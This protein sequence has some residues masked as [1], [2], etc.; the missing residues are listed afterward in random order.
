MQKNAIAVDLKQST[1]QTSSTKHTLLIVDDE[2]RVLKALKRVFTDDNYKILTAENGQAALDILTINN[3]DLIISDYSMPGM[4]GIELLKIIREKYPNTI[5]IM[6]TAH[7]DSDLVM[8]AVN[9]GAVYK[10]I[11][12][13][14][15]DDD[16][17]LTIKLALAQ[18]D[19]IKENKKLKKVAQRQSNEINKLKYFASIDH[20][21]LGTI[22]IDKGI[23]LPGQLEM[24][25]KYRKQNNTILV[26]S[27]IDLGM[28]EEEVLLKVIQELSKSDFA[29]FEEFRLESDFSRL[30]PREACEIGCLAPVRKEDKHIYVAMADPLD[31]ERIE[32]IKFV[33]QMNVTALLARLAEIEKAIK[34]IYDGPENKIDIITEA[35]DEIDIVLDEEDVTTT[36]QLMAK[37]STPP[38]IRMVNTIIGEAIRAEASDIHIE[39]K[40]QYTLVRFRIDGLLHD[41]I[42]LPSTMHLSTISRLKILAKMDIAERRIPQDGRITIKFNDKL[43]DTRVSSMPT[44]NGEKMV[45]RLLEKNAAIKSLTETGIRGKSYDRLI[46]ITSVPQGMIIATGPTGSGKTTTLYSMMKKR[47]SN[48]QNFVTIEDPVEYLLEKASQIHIHNKI[49]LTFASSLRSTLRQDP[50]VILVGE[51][52]DL[53]TAKAAFQAAMTGHLVF[54]S[55]HTNSTIATISRLFHLGIEPF[56]V[57]SA[58]QG[59][60]AQRLVRK[61]CPHCKELKNYDKNLLDILSAENIGFPEKLYYGKGCDNCNQTGFL[62]RT[63]LFEVFQMNEEFR[64]FLTTDYRESKLL[65]MAKSLGMET[66]LEDSLIKVIDG[67]TTLEEILRVL[68]P[69]VEYDY[70]CKN[71][72]KGLDIKFLTCPYC[73][74]AQKK[75]CK[76]CQAQLESDWAACPY[77]G[78]C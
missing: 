55:L 43:V 2:I 16:L 50:D 40:P 7:S 60:I 77:C 58:V 76:N 62:G 42:K 72:G 69:G 41:R 36:E 47:L 34:Y 12:K 48:S 18:Y 14:W 54:T 51:I 29:P 37:S 53:E 57:A 27:L 44:I 21:P 46:N 5:R 49:G 71:C 13:P 64:H 56:L 9:D 68:G 19:L 17:R 35:P 67:W 61:V 66:L 3:V 28:V 59:I 32:Y 75:I 31:L 1:D 24:V 23:V 30:L 6:L 39:P 63:G 78:Q 65:N 33:T 11:T 8:A 26:K 70:C 74:T 15:N 38:T 20:S 25:E 10:F 22:L 73:G 52:R 45:L 4:S